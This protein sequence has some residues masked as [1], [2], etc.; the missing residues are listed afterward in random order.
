MTKITLRML[1]LLL[2]LWMAAGRPAYSQSPTINQDARKLSMALYAVAN[3]YVD[4]VNSEKLA[5]DA[6]I[7]ML[8]KLD[9]HS[10]YLNK[11]ETKELTEPLQGNFDGIG[12]QF[13]M[14]TDTLYVIQ[15]IPGGPSEK[16]GL[17]AGDRIIMV[18]DTLIAGVQMKTNDIMKRLRGPKGTLVTVKVLRKDSPELIEFKITRGKIPMTSMDAAYMA[19]KTTGYI[20]LNR[21]S[22]TSADEIRE[23]L[24][25]LKKQGMKNLIL[26]LQGNGGGYLNAAIDLADEFLDDNKLIVYTQGN[27]QRREEA[28][29][30]ARGDFEKGSLIILIDES[31][32]SASEIVSGAVQDWDRGVLVGR[33]SFG[34]GLVQKP[35][36][37]PDGT[38]IKLTVAR[39]YT[40]T[41]RCIQKPY[42]SG[43]MDQYNLELIKRFDHGELMHADSIHFSD[44]LKY[45]TLLSGRTVYGGG[46]IMPDIFVPL[47]TTRT[48][49]Y[50]RELVAKGV[51]YRAS[52]NYIDRNR[53]ELKKSYPT[54]EKYKNKFEINDEIWNDVQKLA[55]E[56]KIEFNEEQFKQSKPLI[57]LQLK[58]LIARDLFDMNEYFIIIN[59]INESLQK[60]LEIIN[61][62][63]EYEKILQK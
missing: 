10:N 34:K 1:P 47:D 16:V 4:S 56:E 40:P 24:A 49:K 44:S 15:V 50:H 54:I 23:A 22:A 52:M 35:L 19:D 26:D 14:L 63:E 33:R 48:T 46:G 8:E 51:I 45:N 53:N 38:L 21:F 28:T 18:N 41:G 11:E 3:L 25:K 5:E 39:Y 2:L 58:A 32:A 59:D 20:K 9:P 57:S 37:M 12:I 29:S 43:N 27:K 13:N 60:A 55:K 61:N 30:T 31:S 17:R 36:P 6:I 42:E 7:G 62:P